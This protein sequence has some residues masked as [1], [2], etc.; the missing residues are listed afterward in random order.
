MNTVLNKAFKCASNEVLIGGSAT[1][2]FR[3]QPIFAAVIVVIGTKSSMHQIIN[4]YKR[5]STSILNYIWAL[6]IREC[7]PTLK[8]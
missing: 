1:I 2:I 3:T 8:K 5:L 7:T 6:W 4:I